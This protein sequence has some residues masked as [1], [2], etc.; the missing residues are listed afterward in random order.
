M[1]V[2]NKHNIREFQYFLSHFKLNYHNQ[3]YQLYSY[4]AFKN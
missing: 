1:W 2:E 3:Y 4:I